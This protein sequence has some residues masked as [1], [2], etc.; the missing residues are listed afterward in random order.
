L[1][2]LT[3]ISLFISETIQSYYGTPVGTLMQ[4]I[5]WC[6]FQWP[7]PTPKP[8]FKLII[9]WWIFEKRYEI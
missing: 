2:F 8:H 9:W 4:S 5:E 1:Q 6:H 7:W 3:N